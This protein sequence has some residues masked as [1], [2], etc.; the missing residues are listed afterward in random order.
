[1]TNK[2][3]LGLAIVILAIFAVDYFLFAGTLP[4][5]LS[6][7]LLVLTEYLAFWR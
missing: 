4:L 3:A 6:R 7:K 5:F 2:I 1:M